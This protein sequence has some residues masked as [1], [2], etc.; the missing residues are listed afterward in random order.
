VLD[1]N[2]KEFIV[3]LNSNKVKYSVVGG[4]V[5][6]FYGHPRYAKEIDAWVLID[7]NNVKGICN[8]LDQFGFADLSLK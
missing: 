3:L 1:K 5:L 8:T 2:F 6:A 7:S 4:Y